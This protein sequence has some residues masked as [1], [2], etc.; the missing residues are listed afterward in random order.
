MGRAGRSSV[1]PTCGS[2]RAVHLIKKTIGL[3]D[4]FHLNTYA[5][6]ITR[7]WHVWWNRLFGLIAFN[8]FVAAIWL[9]G[10]DLLRRRCSERPA[11]I[12]SAFLLVAF[13]AMNVNSAIE[14]RYGLPVAPT[15]FMLF[16]A[17]VAE[18]ARSPERRERRLFV[19]LAAVCSIGFLAQAVVWDAASP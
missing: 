2:T 4:N 18:I 9:L 11:L 17:L 16:G 1:S 3:F 5:V 12:F 8:G 10:R 14:S 7:P 19:G 6:E 15:A 13:V